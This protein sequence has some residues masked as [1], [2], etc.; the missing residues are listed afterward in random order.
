M[1]PE[2]FIAGSLVDER[3]DIYSF[4]ITLFQM[5]TGGRLPFQIDAA[6]AQSDVHYYYKLHQKY[7]PPKVD[8][9]LEPRCL[10]KHPNERYQTFEDLQRHLNILFEEETGRPYRSMKA[11]EMAASEHMNY[12]ASYFILTDS[13]RALH[14]ID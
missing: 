9:A 3:S 2:Q 6:L 1:P 7:R 12:A 10:Q 13:L 11:Q 5:V 14:H 4:G 8:G